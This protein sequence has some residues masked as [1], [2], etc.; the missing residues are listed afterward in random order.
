M[1]TLESIESMISDLYERHIETVY[2]VCYT[3][4]GNKQDAED[5]AQTVFI[6]LMRSNLTFHD[7]EHEKAWLITTARNHCRD[8]HRRW[9]RKKVVELSSSIYDEQNR[10]MPT[11]EMTDYILRLPPN[12]RLIL[13]LYYYEGYKLREI[14]DLLKM[15][16]N[17][18]KTQ[19]RQARKRLK[20]EI[21]DDYHE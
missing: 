9:W 18:V 1:K 10:M 6:K 14:A 3:M 20:Q 21:G 12:Q 16:I 15:N 13:Y 17:T 11:Y 8:E 19:M 2:R 7:V 4:M 5:A